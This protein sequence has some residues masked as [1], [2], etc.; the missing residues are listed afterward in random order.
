MFFSQNICSPQKLWKNDP[1]TTVILFSTRWLKHQVSFAEWSVEVWPTWS[2]AFSIGIHRQEA[3][4]LRKPIFTFMFSML[5][6]SLQSYNILHP[7]KSE[8]LEIFIFSALHG[9]IFRN[10]SWPD[11]WGEVGRCLGRHAPC[12]FAVAPLGHGV[13][14]PRFFFETFRFL[15]FLVGEG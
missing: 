8:L 13:R 11:N 3:S 7:P 2:Y 9:W 1:V 6:A 12:H 4:P 15:S 14:I 5:E 10:K